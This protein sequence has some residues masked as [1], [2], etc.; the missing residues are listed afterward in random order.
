MPGALVLCAA[1]DGENP[2]ATAAAI[3]HHF[4]FHVSDADLPNILAPL[5]NLGIWP[6]RQEGV[7]WWDRLEEPQR[8]LA[9]ETLEPYVVHLAGGGLGA[10]VWGRELF[11]INEQQSGEQ[12]QPA[13]R[14]ADITGRPR[15]VVLGPY[16]TLPPGSW[17][18]TVDLGFSQAAAEMSYIVDVHADAQLA[19]VRIEP[20]AQRFVQASLTFSIAEPKMIA[21]GV[22]NE[23]AAFD[24]QI[25]LGHVT[26]TPQAKIRPE[27]HNYLAAAFSE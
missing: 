20:G 23:R 3:A 22:W 10:L 5:S 18:A 26:M 25:A 9:T 24:G 7:C 21:V 27:T 11:F 17:S 4:G 16:I 2:T 15:Y 14:P 19:C 1:T 6:R 12:R 8:V 13:S